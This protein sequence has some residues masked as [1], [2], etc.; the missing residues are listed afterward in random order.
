MR[1]NGY[2]ACPDCGENK[3][4]VAKT[5]WNCMIKR[6]SR[7][8]IALT[9]ERGDYYAVAL[10]DGTTALVDA[11]DYQR[12][13]DVAWTASTY[14]YAQR[15]TAAGTLYLHKVVL[16]VPS[17]VEVDH[18]DGNVL[19]CRRYNLRPCTHAE[20][21]HN[22]GKSRGVYS[23]RY[24]GVRWR[25][26]GKRWESRIALLGKTIQLGQFTSED[27][28]AR[29]YNDAAL[30]YHGEFARLNIILETPDAEL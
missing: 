1:P 25:K 15:E 14:G 13:A 26:Q 5:C 20:N 10:S 7:P 23:S 3:R 24:K 16:N 2:D 30:L 21:C 27:A 19:N 8:G 22:R 28:A 9:D 29:A 6:S 4:T 12:V 18:V 11:V 17:S